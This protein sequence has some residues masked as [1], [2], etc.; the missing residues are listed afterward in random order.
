M[1]L[2]LDRNG[3]SPDAIDICAI[4][5]RRAQQHASRTGC[6]VNMWQGDVTW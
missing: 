4:V 2:E 5:A 3:V 6:A 1:A